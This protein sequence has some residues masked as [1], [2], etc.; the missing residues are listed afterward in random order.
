MGNA[1]MHQAA[2]R[3]IVDGWSGTAVLVVAT[4]LAANVTLLIGIHAPVWDA[5]DLGVPT[6][7]LLADTVR[8]GQWLLWTPLVAGGC[9]IGLDPGTGAFSPITVG[10]AGLLG[11][12]EFAFRIYWLTIWAIGGLGMVFLARHLAAPRWMAYCAAIGF[13]FSG[14][15][16]GHA[17]HTS[18]LYTASFLPWVIWRLD[19][20]VQRRSWS[21]ALQAGALCG[22]SGQGGY[23]GMVILSGFFAGLWLLLALLPHNGEGVATVTEK[24]SNALWRKL[25]VWVGLATVFCVATFVVLAPSYLGFLVETQN[26]SDRAGALPRQVAVTSNALHPWSLTTAVSPYFMVVDR[27]QRTVFPGTDPSTC[28][29]YVFPLLLVLAAVS[30]AQRPREAFRWCIAATALFCLAAALGDWLPV[31]GWLYDVLPPMRY[32]RHSGMFRC[33]YIFCV[34]V[35]AMLVAGDLQTPGPRQNV[36]WRRLAYCYTAAAAMAIAVFLLFCWRNPPNAS[37]RG[38][39]PAGIVEFLVVWPGI[40]T[41]VWI[42]Y[43]KGEPTRQHI[44]QKHLVCFALAEAILSIVVGKSLMFTNRTSQHWDQI[45]ASHVTIVDD[46]RQN[47]IRAASSDGDQLRCFITKQPVFAGYLVLQNQFVTETAKNQTLMKTVAGADRCWFARHAVAMRL[48]RKNFDLFARHITAMPRPGLAVSSPLGPKA[49]D[50]E[51]WL[52]R[53]DLTSWTFDRLVPLEPQPASYLVRQSRVIEFETICPDFG[54][55]LVTDRWAN[56]WTASVNGRMRPIAI[57]NFLF[58]AIPVEK[59]LNRIR[60]EYHPFGYPWLLLASWSCMAAAASVSFFGRRRSGV[61]TG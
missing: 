10:M 8:A 43:R 22:L 6:F 59:G 33:Y 3:R 53:K 4:L 51:P 36:C 31:R 58:Q 55:L 50:V 28:C 47:I 23:P 15:F 56:G 19:V 13:M 38:Y 9:P 14:F 46:P 41:T 57:G 27:F 16:T 30:L 35:L 54:W 49:A 42:G 48:N 11:G 5:A 52:E 61:S 21:A 20:A 37:S 44:L 29:I 24:T 18:L 32:F 34:I 1:R 45:E 7:V 39:L 60:L 2:T 25:L 40:A 17:Q 26:Y 12:S